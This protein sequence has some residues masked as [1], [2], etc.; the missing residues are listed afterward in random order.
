MNLND[1]FEMPSFDT[2]NT[3]ISHVASTANSEAVAKEVAAGD[4]VVEILDNDDCE[5]TLKKAIGIE[6]TER[7]RDKE[8]LRNLQEF[9]RG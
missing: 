3:V 6:K 9:C 2:Q 5:W 4:K 1:S 7:V 8:C